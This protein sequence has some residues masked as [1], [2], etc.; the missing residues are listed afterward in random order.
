MLLAVR[1]YDMS[2]TSENAQTKADKMKSLDNHCYF[3][4]LSKL[5]PA[6]MLDDN[7]GTDWTVHDVDSSANFVHSAS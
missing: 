1:L 3:C 6:L 5:K 4:N 2:V 7:D